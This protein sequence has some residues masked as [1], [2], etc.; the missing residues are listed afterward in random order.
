MLKLLRYTFQS[1]ARFLK[2][3]VAVFI[4]MQVLIILNMTVF[5]QIGSNQIERETLSF[6]FTFLLFVGTL[7]T[8]LCHTFS[9]FRNIIK[10]SLIRLLPIHSWK[11]SL[12]S[13][14]YW[15]IVAAFIQILAFIGVQLI[16]LLATET[17]YTEILR[18]IRVI[19]YM[20]II[21]AGYQ[22]SLNILIQLF[23]SFVLAY[24]L[25]IMSKNKGILSTILFFACNALVTVIT[26]KISELFPNGYILQAGRIPYEGG[27]VQIG[28]FS[29][30]IHIYGSFVNIISLLGLFIA[31]A[32]LIEKRVEI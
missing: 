7:I 29:E 21:S 25:P 17:E 16:S 22:M 26:S 31:T 30:G 4:I 13:L 19:D 14:C 18:Q 5:H 23:F 1:N 9:V 24:S 8:L 32:W 20:W 10:S 2:V 6:I 15:V 28:L 11:Y 12:A 27:E 3:L